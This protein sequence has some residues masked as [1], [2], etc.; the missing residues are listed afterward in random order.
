[1]TVTGH[2]PEGLNAYQVIEAGQTQINHI[3]Y[4]ADIMHAPYPA[5]MSRPDRRKATGPI[6]TST[7]PRRRRRLLF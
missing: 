4:V 2:V 5:D 3:G 7:L 1:M 6:W